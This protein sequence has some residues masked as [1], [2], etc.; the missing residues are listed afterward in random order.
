MRSWMAVA[1]AMVM[2]T[3]GAATPA[4]AAQDA[5]HVAEVGDWG[6]YRYPGYCRAN[7][8]FGDQSVNVALDPARDLAVLHIRS[9]TFAGFTD[10]ETY[11]LA[12]LLLS[13][14]AVD[15]AMGEVDFTAI[16]KSDFVG[17]MGS[18]KASTLFAHLARASALA[19]SYRGRKV[20]AFELG[21][22]ARMIDALK[23]C[24]GG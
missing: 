19:L 23:R 21:P 11:P 6:I 22:V 17:A 4:G 12:V 2:A 3:T 1:M 13:D 9:A 5:E 8:Q 14:G 18:M 7:G 20:Q 15:E 10:G 16:I 24:A